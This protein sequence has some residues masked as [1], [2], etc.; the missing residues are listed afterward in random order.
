MRAMAAPSVA[1]KKISAPF[2][3]DILIQAPANN[4]LLPLLRPRLIRRKIGDQ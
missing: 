2:G 3:A 4:Q 1:G